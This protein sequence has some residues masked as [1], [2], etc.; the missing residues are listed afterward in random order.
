M[1]AIWSRIRAQF[2]PSW[3]SSEKKPEKNGKIE[4]ENGG[5]WR[6]SKG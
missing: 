1:P 5:N 3:A 6:F 4:M 2:A